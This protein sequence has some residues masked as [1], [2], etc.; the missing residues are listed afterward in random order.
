MIF[1]GAAGAKC[2][3]TLRQENFTGE[4]VLLSKENH[5]PYDRPKLTKAMNISP[6]QISLRNAQFYE[7]NIF[8]FKSL[9]IIIIG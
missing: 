9:L 1:I 3:E 4:I 8:Y 5:L 6:S 2:V 7:V